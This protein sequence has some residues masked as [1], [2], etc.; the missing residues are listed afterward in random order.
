MFT[1]YI[2]NKDNIMIFRTLADVPK[3]LMTNREVA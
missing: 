1:C 2:Q 3:L